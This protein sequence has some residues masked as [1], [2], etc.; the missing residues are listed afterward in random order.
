MTQRRRGRPAHPNRGLVLALARDPNMT[1]T[2]IAKVAG[3]S[4]SAVS[5]WVRLEREA[6]AG[7][8][9]LVPGAVGN[10]EQSL[11]VA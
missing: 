10:G 6:N 5:L 11:E 2:A 3:V 9:S 8:S 1:L 4:L 7:D